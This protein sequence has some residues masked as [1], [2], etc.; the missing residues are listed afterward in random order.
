MRLLFELTN[1]ALISEYIEM[2]KLNLLDTS[3][4]YQKIE[5]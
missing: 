5:L 3:K 1:I 4:V 2:T